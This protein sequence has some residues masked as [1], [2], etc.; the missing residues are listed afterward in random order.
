MKK[1]IFVIFIISSIFL[2]SGLIFGQNLRANESAIFLRNGNMIIGEIVDISSARRVLQLKD[3]TEIKLTNIW[4]INFINTKW[5]FPGERKQIKTADH[6]F[7]LKNGSIIYGKII[8]FSSNL[9]VFELDTGE[10]IKIGAIRRIYFSKRVPNQLRKEIEKVA[11][12]FLKDGTVISGEIIDFSLSRMVLVLKG[13][14]E[15]KLSA[16]DMINFVDKG[17]SF[18]SERSR[19]VNPRIY[20]IF[21]KDGGVI[22]GRIAGFDSNAFILSSGER[23]N[24]NS[25]KR[26]YFPRSF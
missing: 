7:F 21:L 13:G 15:I 16:I 26:I 12:V 10:K 23:V 24:I 25:I 11:T 17:R 18:P 20:Y 1:L 4:M 9:R 19:I 22:T 8:D 6:Y 14:N 2:W 5:N 3:G